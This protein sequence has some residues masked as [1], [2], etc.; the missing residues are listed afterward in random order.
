[1]V[2]GRLSG[3]SYSYRAVFASCDRGLGEGGGGGRGLRR[4]RSI[5]LNP[6]MILY[7]RSRHA[8]AK[9]SPVGGFPLDSP[10]KSGFPS[11]HM[12]DSLAKS[13]FDIGLLMRVFLIQ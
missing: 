5:T 6:L 12:Q 2:T 13:E 11:L 4:S 9:L 3:S 1:M 8:S 7:I 10:A